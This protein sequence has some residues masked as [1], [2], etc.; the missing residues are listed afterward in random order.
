MPTFFDGELIFV[1]IPKCAGSSV[2]KALEKYHLDHKPELV[3]RP[4][5]YRMHESL[6][7]VEH[8]FVEK[9]GVERWK[10]VPVI[11]TFRHP[12]DRAVSWWKFIKKANM[13]NFIN[14]ENPKLTTHGFSATT[15]SQPWITPEDHSMYH[16]KVLPDPPCRHQT[17]RL[18]V[19]EFD[20][21]SFHDFID[22]VTTWKK[23]GCSHPNCPYHMLLPQV[24]WL[25]DLG[26]NLRMDNLNLFLVE[27]LDEL[28]RFLP[29]MGK[30]GRFNVTKERGEDYRDH[31]TTESLILL[32]KLYLEDFKLY[33]TLKDAPPHRRNPIRFSD[34]HFI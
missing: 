33:R 34:K 20:S 19:E 29:E 32:N 27:R 24:Y 13:K 26:G 23:T 12:V 9:W 3:E 10:G 16:H 7:E 21:L 14:H 1:H 17:D 25:Y 28:E 31:I 6:L 5:M 30:L 8:L 15:S 2:Y 4:L 11:S 18:R 22:R